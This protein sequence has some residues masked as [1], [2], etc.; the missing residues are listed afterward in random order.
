M[1]QG[2]LQADTIWTPV[3]F[4]L[5]QAFVNKNRKYILTQTIFPLCQYSISESLLRFDGFS[6]SCNCSQAGQKQSRLRT[7][8]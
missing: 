3:N 7:P 2:R 5:L 1:L 8:N 6:R 4:V